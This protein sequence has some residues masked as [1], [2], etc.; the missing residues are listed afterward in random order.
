M[1]H[2]CTNGFRK[3]IVWQEAKK[4]TLKIYRLTKK[5]PKEELF[6]M[7]SQMRRASTSIMANLA[8]G[9]AMPTKAHRDSYY[10]RARGSAVEIDNFTELAF[11]LHYASKQEFDDVSDHC[12][13]IV[14]LTIRLVSS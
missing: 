7:S 13:R 1:Y 5:F 14:H 10:V 11:E 4:L 12:A 2:R 8:E 3:L 9:S 6:G